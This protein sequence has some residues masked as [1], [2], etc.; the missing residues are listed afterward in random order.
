M[1]AWQII[2]NEKRKEAQKINGRKYE[3]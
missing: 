3:K 2:S 1:A